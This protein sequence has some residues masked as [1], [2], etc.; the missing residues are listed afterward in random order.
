MA[1]IPIDSTAD[2]PKLPKPKGTGGGRRNC[3]NWIKSY[4]KLTEQLESPEPFHLYSGLFALSAA[5]GRKAVLDKGAYKLYPNIFVILVAG[6]ALCRKTT[7]IE[8]A[9]RVLKMADPSIPIVAQK[10]TQEM[11]LSSLAKQ[12]KEVGRSEAIIVAEELGVFLGADIRN[13]PLVQVLTKL[14]NCSD[15]IDYSTIT[16]GNETCQNAYCCMLGGTTPEWLHAAFPKQSAE[17]GF[18]GRCMF[19][20]AESPRDR[21]AFP[22]VDQELVVKLAAD[23]RQIQG[24]EGEFRIDEDGVAWYKN[25]YE[26]DFQP[27]LSDA[28][29]DG[30]YGRKH[31]TLLKV[32]MLISVSQRSDL[33]LNSLDL[34]EALEW[35][36][37]LEK[38]YDTAMRAM[39]TTEIGQNL[40]QV[41]RTI[42]GY[43]WTG[44]PHSKL[45]QRL[46]YKMSAAEIKEHLDMLRSS[47]AITA[48]QIGNTGV[49]VQIWYKAVEQ[50]LKESESEELGK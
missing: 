11:L 48:T 5:L 20:Y 17:G 13:V 23:L 3:E 4:L 35:L 22:R 2:Q 45:L 12:F 30:Y 31:D 41:L 36:D 24:L 19:V 15:Y 33:I 39:H 38:H 28:T 49:G 6:S 27:K 21:C 9:I 7:A 34:S 42:H 37:V 18:T 8:F 14:Y 16:R 25:W 47:G 44:I 10:I 43:G 46:S 29:M 40:Q 50:P 26:H 1:L 32:A